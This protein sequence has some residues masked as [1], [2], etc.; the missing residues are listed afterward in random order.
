M[1]NSDLHPSYRASLPSLDLAP[2]FGIYGSYRPSR[3]VRRTRRFVTESH[4]LGAP[5]ARPGPLLVAATV[6]IAVVL[7]ARRLID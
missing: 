5:I 6:A 1:M 3:D 4:A 7:I 2:G